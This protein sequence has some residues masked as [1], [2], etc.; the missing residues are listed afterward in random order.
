MAALSAKR[1][2]NIPRA[3]ENAKFFKQI[4]INLSK[5]VDFIFVD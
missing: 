3:K 1:N 4:G 5:A 2:V